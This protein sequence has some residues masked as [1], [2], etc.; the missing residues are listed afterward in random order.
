MT[1][2]ILQWPFLPE[3]QRTPEQNERWW[4]E[5]YLPS[6]P[7]VTL[8]SATYSVIVYGG[9]GSGKSVA[10]KALEKVMAKH[11]LVAHYPTHLW[12]GQ[13]NDPAA[14][15]SH[16]S[17]MMACAAATIKTLL[18][19]Q[20][21][22]LTGLTPINLEYLRWL[23]EKYSGARAFRRWA[24]AMEQMSLLGLLNQPF[25]D[26]YPTDPS[27]SDAQGQIEEL[28]TLSRRLGFAG[29]GIFVDINETEI[30]NETVLEK[31]TALFSWL[32]PLQIEGFAIKAAL[33]AGLVE[34]ANLIERSRGRVKFT[35][36]RWS[37]ENCRKLSQRYLCAATQDELTSPTKIAA[38]GL[39]FSLEE[40]IKLLYP[41]PVPQPWIRLT[42]LLLDHYVQSGQRLTEMQFETL[43][44]AYFTRYVPL[45]F[46]RKRR[47]VWRGHQWIALD[48]KPFKF[49]ET[50][51]SFRDGGD[52]TQAL[53]KVA[54]KQ[55]N[56]N[57]L[58]SR[59]RKKI[60]PIPGQSVYIHNNR[61][62]GYWLENVVDVG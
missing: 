40:Q 53:L 35:L 26:L 25:V 33:P 6:L 32:L 29:V 57:T 7:D 30:S 10:L 11:L 42:S 18:T 24:D 61:S 43:A 2:T 8:Q 38:E 12:S 60:E 13:P 28:V 55:G 50:L 52:A 4:A 62:Q 15:Y 47:G 19:Q 51:W 20:P 37:I 16:L 48:D 1:L 21:E 23:I 5:C 17:Q 36:L 56:L 45:K 27:Q 41:Q 14:N 22:K 49:L 39:L 58:A 54:G 44:C 59:V 3:E 31:V 9:P 34:Q 46:D